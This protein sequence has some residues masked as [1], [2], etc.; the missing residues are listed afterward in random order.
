MVD[1]YVSEVVTLGFDK[2]KIIVTGNIV[3]PDCFLV[4]MEDLIKEKE[5]LGTYLKIPFFDKKGN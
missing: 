3:H 2:L 4:R 5:I 1:W